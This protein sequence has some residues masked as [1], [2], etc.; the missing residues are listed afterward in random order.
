MRVGDLAQITQLH[1][2]FGKSARDQC[3]GYRVALLVGS[4]QLT[5]ALGFK[6]WDEIP[7]QN[8]PIPCRL[9]TTEL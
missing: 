8:G 7:I 2:D 5:N 4:R 6:T 3:A 9:L 1:R